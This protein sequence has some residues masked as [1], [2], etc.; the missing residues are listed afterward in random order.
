MGGERCRLYNDPGFSLGIPER[1]RE[2]ET[3][4]VERMN[5]TD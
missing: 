2:R 5:R 3:E 1:E 4:T